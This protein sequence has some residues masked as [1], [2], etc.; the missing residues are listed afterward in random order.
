MPETIDNYI[1]SCHSCENDQLVDVLCSRC[2]P[3]RAFIAYP[4]EESPGAPLLCRGCHEAVKKADKD[5]HP[6]PS[7]CFECR[8]TDLGWRRH[9]RGEWKSEAIDIRSSDE[10][11]IVGD[12]DGDFLGQF[13][14]EFRELGS[15]RGKDFR[16]LIE[17]ERA[18]IENISMIGGPP[19]VREHHGRTPP[20][21]FQYLDDVLI[22]R[23]GTEGRTRVYRASLEDIRLHDWIK[24]IDESNRQSP[25]GRLQGK[26]Y[27]RL[28]V[29]K[30]PEPE[31]V[32]TGIAETGTAEPR[33]RKPGHP[34]PEPISEPTHDDV[35]YCNTCNIFV[36][37][38]VSLILYLACS[39][40]TAVLGVLVMLIQCLW[41]SHRMSRSKNVMSDNAEIGTAIALCALAVLVCLAANDGIC[42]QSS[43]WWLAGMALLL[44]LTALLRRCWPW[45]VI[46]LLWILML[47]ALFCKSLSGDCVLP[48]P[49]TVSNAPNSSFD[50]VIPSLED[51]NPIPALQQAASNVI[52]SINQG[53]AIDQNAHLVQGENSGRVSLDQALANPAEFFSCNRPPGIG[54]VPNQNT[55][56]RRPYAITFSEAALFHSGD[57]QL[58][59]GAEAHLQ[60]LARLIGSDP[61]ARLILT[62]HADRSGV[63]EQ[64]LNL[65]LQRAQAVADW[66]VTRGHLKPEQIDV[67]GAGDRYPIVNDPRLY[68]YNRRVDI[69]LDCSERKR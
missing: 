42:I 32:E 50:S 45:L 51:L 34:K 12:F 54:S 57:A 53:L 52:D 69:S 27:G 20:L 16:H 38:A 64:N 48:G 43:A 66:L 26:A 39:W 3:S 5:L 59:P 36:F 49:A 30:E 8:S 9:D 14:S 40:Q 67:R 6:I 21:R 65:S 44:V 63:P 7:H 33:R 41:R 22:Y 58:L 60:K 23:A 17:F 4:S 24:T 15:Q 62:G 1:S 37:G 35:A 68:Q 25:T 13:G 29:P 55:N 46:S 11:W 47:L 56:G 61:K 10:P 2:G 28:R 31:S 18:Q 19:A